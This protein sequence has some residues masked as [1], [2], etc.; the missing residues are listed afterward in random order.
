MSGT[1]RSI[2]RAGVS[3]AILL[4]G[5]AGASAGA[6]GIR[7]QSAEAQGEAFAGAASGSGGISSMFW[8]PAVVTMRPGFVKE[9]NLS[10]IGLSGRITPQAGTNPAF[11]PLGGSNDIGQGAIVPA[12]ATSYQINERLWIGLQTG[13]PFGLV[14]KAR[15]VWAGELYG[16]SNRIF[17]LAFN[18]VIGFKVNEWLSVAAGPNIEYFRLTLRQAVPLPINPAALPSAFLKGDSWGVGFTAGALIT[19]WAGT[20][21]G[22]GYRSSVHHD[23]DG[24]IGVPLLALAPLG[25][26]VTAKLNTPEKLSVGLTQA[27]SPVARVSL[28]FEWDNWTRLGTIGIV[29]KTRGVPVNVLPLN[30]KDG[31]TYSVGGEYDWSP[32][33][34]LRAGVAYEE[35][36]IDFSNR[37]VR[38]PD[39]DRVNVSVGASY[40]WNEKLT[41]HAAYSHLFLDKGRILAG[42]GRDYNVQN[43]A[44]AGV[45]EGSADLVS[46]GFR[47]VFGDVVAPVGAP[48]VRKY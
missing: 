19:P 33:L 5:I 24:S 30:Y 42:V 4:G 23:I 41:L 36:P 47:Y 39:S 20:A 25:G 32:A 3:T 21:L 1:I 29:S 6:F 48:V 7:E 44:F 14:T 40:R 46:V 15:N 28:G 34:T 26:Q 10:F 9:E 11:L 18:P 35:S 45:A 13:A 37:S 16:R 27:I 17:T 2:A 12:G 8:N 31:F 38:L 43:I 22:I